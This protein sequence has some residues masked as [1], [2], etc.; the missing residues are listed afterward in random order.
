MN[1]FVG[2][3]PEIFVFF[4]ESPLKLNDFIIRKSDFGRVDIFVFNLILLKNYLRDFIDM[5][6]RPFDVSEFLK[7]GL[8]VQIHAADTSGDLRAAWCV[9]HLSQV[10]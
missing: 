8:I 4:I 1:F 2:K 3:F 5:K 10:A 9:V 6:Q 7:S